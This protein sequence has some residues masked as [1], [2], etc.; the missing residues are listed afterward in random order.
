MTRT[1]LAFVG[2]VAAR[3]CMRQQVL[4]DAKSLPTCGRSQSATTCDSFYARNSAQYYSVLQSTTKYYS[5]LQSTTPVLQSTTRYY[6]STVP[7]FSV[8]QSATPVL[9]HYEV[10]LQ[11]YSVLRSTTPV[12]QSRK[13]S[14][15]AKRC[16]RALGALAIKEQHEPAKSNECGGII[17]DHVVGSMSFICLMAFI[18]GCGIGIITGGDLSGL[19][20]I[21]G[22]WTFGAVCFVKVFL[23][24]MDACAHLCGDLLWLLWGF[25]QELL[26]CCFLGFLVIIGIGYIG[27]W[28]I[29]CQATCAMGNCG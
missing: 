27:W 3:S 15:T 19:A 14:S 17:C 26:A 25:Q 21:L 18:G 10:L 4:N 29:M 9:L 28:C 12:L 22:D 23:T 5:V 8:L 6:S 24:I 20:A 1:M 11:Y 13:L 7:Y 16:F 2:F